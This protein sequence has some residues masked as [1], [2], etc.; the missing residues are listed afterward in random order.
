MSF[1]EA[2][3][4]VDVDGA[5]TFS[6]APPGRTSVHIPDGRQLWDHILEHRE[7]VK[8]V[9]HMHPGSGVPEPS[10]EDTT[11]FAAI[12]RG[13][14]RRLAWWIVTENA[15]TLFMWNGERYAVHITWWN[16]APTQPRWVGY[17]RSLSDTQGG[18]S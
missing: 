18:S 14:G 5:V 15:C 1:A 13:L 3:V 8:G 9:A 7:T 16:T 4:V 2:A 11:T 6:W 10:H 12:E 17:L